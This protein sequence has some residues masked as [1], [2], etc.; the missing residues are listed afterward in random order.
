MALP[1]AGAMPT[2]GVS[3]RPGR[4]LILAVDQHG[5]EHG[6]I[7]ETRDTVLGEARIQNLSVLKVNRFKQRPSDAHDVRALDLILSGGRD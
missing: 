7:A 6:D 2:I 4:W 1:T 5:L 3:P